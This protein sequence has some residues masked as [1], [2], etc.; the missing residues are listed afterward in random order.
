M[1]KSWEIVK[2]II[3]IGDLWGPLLICLALA[4]T[5]SLSKPDNADYIFATIFFIIWFGAGVVTLN[6]KLLGGKM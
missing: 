1:E 6:A 5:L 3:L 2:F 4:L